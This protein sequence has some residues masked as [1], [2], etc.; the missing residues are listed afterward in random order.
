MDANGLDLPPHH[1]D[2]LTTLLNEYESADGPVKAARLADLQDR[3]TGTVQNV[4]GKLSALGVVD[5]VPGPTGGYCPT[6]RAFEVA[7]RAGE[8]DTD[9]VV[10]ARD[11]DRVDVTVERIE[12]VA[13][14]DPDRCRAHVRVRDTTDSLGA[15]DPVAVGP[16]TPGDLVIA[17]T[18]VALPDAGADLIVDVQSAEAPLTRAE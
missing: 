18:V 13:V 15:G 17:G 3:S 8:G 6:D 9:P 11:F 14:H 4:M 16:A 12:F 1:R 2:L 5:G 10:L 7:G